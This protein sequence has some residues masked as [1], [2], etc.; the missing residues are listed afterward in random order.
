VHDENSE[1]SIVAQ[2]K[3]LFVP[4]VPLDRDILFTGTIGFV[5][6]RWGATTAS[7]GL[8]RRENELFFCFAFKRA[9]PDVIQFD[10]INVGRLV[11]SWLQAVESI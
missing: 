2:I 1:R 10:M 6:G 4:R 11:L 3:S 8:V 7:C 9:F 5:E